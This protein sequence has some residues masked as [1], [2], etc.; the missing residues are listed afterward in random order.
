MHPF[1]RIPLFLIP[2][3]LLH[4][5]A[6][7]GGQGPRESPTSGRMRLSAESSLQG[8]ASTQ[9]GLFTRYYP[10]AVIDV[11]PADSPGALQALIG[12]RCDAALAS[13]APDRLPEGLRLERVGRDAVVPVVNA[14][15]PLRTLS[16]GELERVFTLGRKGTVPLVPANDSVLLRILEQKGWSLKAFGTEGDGEML[17]RIERDPAAMGL[18]LRSAWVEM[19]AEGRLPSNVRLLALAGV[20]PDAENILRGSYPFVVEVCYIYKNGD[21]LPA[22]FG[23]WLSGQGQKAMEEGPVVPWKLLERTIILSEQPPSDPS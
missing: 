14:G 22:G 11:H 9:A 3:L 18:M 21:P 8:T 7:T 4:M 23:A 13:P 6:C 5:T 1:R 16:P 15:S 17:R 12:G 10:E 20:R 19:K 2:L